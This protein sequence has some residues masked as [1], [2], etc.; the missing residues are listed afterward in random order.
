MFPTIC[1][2]TVNRIIRHLVSF[3]KNLQKNYLNDIPKWIQ[4]IF[5][6]CNIL[7]AS[8]RPHSSVFS[9]KTTPQA[10]SISIW[11]YPDHQPWGKLLGWSVRYP[12]NAWVGKRRRARNDAPYLHRWFFI[13]ITPFFLKSESHFIIHKP[14]RSQSTCTST[15]T[16]LARALADSVSVSARLAPRGA[17]F[18]PVGTRYARCLVDRYQPKARHHNSTAPSPPSPP[19]S[20]DT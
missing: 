3:K 19:T 16:K 6:P 15:L 8:A 1:S 2:S 10:K 13:W 5:L 14:A 11:D 9:C 18:A 4:S 12:S 17:S 20:E 7:S